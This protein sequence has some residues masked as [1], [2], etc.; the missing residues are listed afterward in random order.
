MAYSL[1]EAVNHSDHGEAFHPE[2]VIDDAE[3]REVYFDQ[4]AVLYAGSMVRRMREHAG[5]SQKELAR[6]IGA[7][8]PPVSD[9]ERG[10]GS[11]GPTYLMLAKVAKAC[12]LALSL[13]V[14]GAGDDPE[15]APLAGTQAD[16]TLP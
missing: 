1:G 11:Q 5:L 6:H 9:I 16:P 10:S 7:S 12:G 4:A 3:G 13:C 15:L 8:Q 14:A 2:Q